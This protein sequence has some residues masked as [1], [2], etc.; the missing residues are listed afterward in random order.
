MFPFFCNFQGDSGKFINNVD[1]CFDSISKMFAFKIIRIKKL[2]RFKSRHKEKY[3]ANE[4]FHE[5]ERDVGICCLYSD[6]K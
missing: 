2:K 1:Q 4:F 3:L 6:V 5:F